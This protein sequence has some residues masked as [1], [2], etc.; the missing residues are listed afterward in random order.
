MNKFQA[1]SAQVGA[2]TVA[3]GLLYVIASAALDRDV[4][5]EEVKRE[6]GARTRSVGVIGG[7][8][9]SS[10]DEARFATTYEANVYDPSRPYRELVPSMNRLGGAQFTYAFWM[11]VTPGEYERTILLRGDPTRVDFVPGVTNAAVGGPVAEG[12]AV[13]CGAGPEVYRYTGGEVRHYPNPAIADTWDPNWGKPVMLDCAGIPRGAPMGP[14]PAGGPIAEGQAV[15]CTK[16]GGVYRYTG[17]KLRGYP[18]PT[19]AGTWDPNWGKPV[20]LDCTGIPRGAA[21]G[22]APKS[23][24]SHPAAFC[25]MIRVK[26]HKNG[27]VQIV[28]HANTSSELNV[29]TVRSVDNGSPFDMT[30]YQLVCVSFE[31]GRIYDAVDGTS[32][33]VWV[34]QTSTRKHSRAA[35]LRENRGDLY[36]FP[37]LAGGGG[38][39]AGPLRLPADS[40]YDAGKVTIRNL[41]YHNYSF[42]ADDVNMKLKGE[43]DA[44]GAVQYAHEGASAAMERTREF[45]DLS[46]Q[47]HDR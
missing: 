34:N 23:T 22:P 12:Q 45:T 43:A 39:A 42:S 17:G 1:I 19:I 44:S 20:L 41:S 35:T 21:M 30:R 26:V 15:Q 5:V 6:S 25:P 7:V 27:D 16:N 9:S 31:D 40:A 32:C 4:L 24:V 11:K 14:A 10:G 29:K 38:G 28:A 18:N 46:M 47:M 3:V 2:A 13:K 37:R 33:T 8:L 36:V